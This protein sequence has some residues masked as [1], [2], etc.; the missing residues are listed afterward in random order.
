MFKTRAQKA[1]ETRQWILTICL[2]FVVI[3][4]ASMVICKL[5]DRLF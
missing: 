1:R 4:L 2:S 5:V 3:V